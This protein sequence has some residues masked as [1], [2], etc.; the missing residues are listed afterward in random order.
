MWWGCLD[1]FK[2][3]MLVPYNLIHTSLIS[4]RSENQ[5]VSE[6][7]CETYSESRRFQYD[8]G[9][10]LP[11]SWSYKN[12][13]TDDE[14]LLDRQR[15]VGWCLFLQIMEIN[16]IKGSTIRHCIHF[17]PIPKWKF[18]YWIS[19]NIRHVDTFFSLKTALPLQRHCCQLGLFKRHKPFLGLF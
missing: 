8:Q 7:I 4:A 10:Y 19:T 17:A 14:N 16:E 12:P 18:C 9:R 3:L 6:D 13:G 1:Y 2:F 15:G 11:E 5:S